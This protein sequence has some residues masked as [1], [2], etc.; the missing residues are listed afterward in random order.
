MNKY[1]PGPYGGTPESKCPYDRYGNF[2]S[3]YRFIGKIDGINVVDL[4]IPDVD[5][6]DAIGL[7]YENEHID[8]SDNIVSHE[9]YQE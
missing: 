7:E 8:H 9:P 6:I 1:H 5:D 2:R 4:D 3:G